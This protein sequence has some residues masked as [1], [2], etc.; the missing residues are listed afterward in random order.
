[1]RIAAGE[2]Q[3]IRRVQRRIERDR[4]DRRSRQAPPLIPQ[5]FFSLPCGLHATRDK[6]SILNRPAPVV[7]A[8]DQARANN[9]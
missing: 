7:R 5:V 2:F 1:M 9:V 3:L 4:L 6:R 8:G